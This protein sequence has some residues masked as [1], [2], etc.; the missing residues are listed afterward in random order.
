MAI[1]QRQKD[2]VNPYAQDAERYNSS[3]RR[4][5]GYSYSDSR[6]K[7]VI[8]AIHDG[9]KNFGIFPDV[10]IIVGA[11][12]PLQNLSDAQRRITVVDAQAYCALYPQN[13]KVVADKFKLLSDNEIFSEL[14]KLANILLSEGVAKS[15]ETATTSEAQF[16]E[17]QTIMP[18]NSGKSG[19]DRI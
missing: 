10:G 6:N 4:G 11:I 15:Y 13:A 9:F 7:F 19:T 1:K 16:I 2:I 8:D 17:N 5:M 12:G 18:S 3:E 14:E